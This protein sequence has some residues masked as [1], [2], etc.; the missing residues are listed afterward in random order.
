VKS[1]LVCFF[2]GFCTLVYLRDAIAITLSTITHT[3]IVDELSRYGSRP[4][5]PA[6]HHKSKSLVNF[7]KVAISRSGQK[8]KTA[9]RPECDVICF[10]FID[11]DAAT[12]LV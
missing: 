10:D 3:V 4:T 1:L 2:D 7:T 5:G 6:T 8:H 12:D 11:A 9:E